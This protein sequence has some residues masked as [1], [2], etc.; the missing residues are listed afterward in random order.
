MSP[1]TPPTMTE[2]TPPTITELGSLRELTLTPSPPGKTGS[3]HD[4]SAFVDNFP[5]IS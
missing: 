1:Y 4:A 2:Y 3:P 5:G